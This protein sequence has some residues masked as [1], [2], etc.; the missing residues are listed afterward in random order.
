MAFSAPS[1]ALCSSPLALDAQSQSLNVDARR[2]AVKPE[3]ASPPLPSRS[4]CST[5]FWS[6]PQT[7]SR[8]YTP[9]AG[10][11]GYTSAA[12]KRRRGKLLLL[13]GLLG[14]VVLL[15]VCSPRRSITF[16]AS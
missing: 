6:S 16:D 14:L 5:H 9:A 10:S 11:A 4:Q 12:S 15:T 3:R 1:L 2:D 13:L 8:R 7:P